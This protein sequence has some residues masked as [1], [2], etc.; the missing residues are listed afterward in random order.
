MGSFVGSD[1]KFYFGWI[2][3]VAVPVLLLLVGRALGLP[4]LLQ[5]S[6]F[7]VLLVFWLLLVL[8]AW[9]FWRLVNIT[10]RKR[11]ERRL[12]SK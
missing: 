3:L 4:L 2:T 6:P 11:A 9:C 10:N 7:V 8:L 5:A 1:G 12:L